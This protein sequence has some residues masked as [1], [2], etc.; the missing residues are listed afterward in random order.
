VHTLLNLNKRKIIHIRVKSCVAVTVSVP[1]NHHTN[2]WTRHLSLCVQRRLQ[3][4]V[5]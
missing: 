5:E 2:R 1:A 3:V 4:G